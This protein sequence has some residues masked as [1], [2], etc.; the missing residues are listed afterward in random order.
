MR[1]KDEMAKDVEEAATVTIE[2]AA[3]RLGISRNS[4]YSA[5]RNGEIPVIRIGRRVLVS[6]AWLERTLSAIT[7]AEGVAA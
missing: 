7:A 3:K 4:A 1:R 2:L 5:A 6:K